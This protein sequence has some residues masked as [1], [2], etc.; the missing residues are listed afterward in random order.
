MGGREAIFWPAQLDEFPGEPDFRLEKIATAP[1]AE[2]LEVWGREGDPPLWW[3]RWHLPTGYLMMHLREEDMLVGGVK[4][5]TEGIEFAY[6]VGEATL[7]PQG[8]VR[9]AVSSRPGYG[10]RIIFHGAREGSMGGGMLVVERPAASDEA[11]ASIA[12]A[13]ADGVSE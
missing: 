8:L 13:V 2:T 12:E 3:L 6:A 4:R 11:L 7:L 9:R 1:S 5:C 10:E